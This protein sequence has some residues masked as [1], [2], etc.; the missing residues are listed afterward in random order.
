MEISAKLSYLRIA[1]R[2]TR[3]LADLVRGKS[4]K[5][6][7]TVLGFTIKKGSLPV[8]K[9]LNQ[10]VASAINN[11][12]LEAD[13]L[14]IAKITVDEG[15]KYKRWRPRARGQ[16]YEIQKK[17]SHITIILEEKVKTKKKK[18]GKVA[19]IE[20]AD[21]IQE[22]TAKTESGTSQA[23]NREIQ[24]GTGSLPAAGRKN[25]QKNIQT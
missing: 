7:Q 15:P 8:L 9:L 13:N 17:T 12:Q 14:Y 22:K 11:F 4:V 5:E 3:L 1:P 25:R 10:A 16:A 6:A 20:K 19:E 23:E 18:A 2:K 21:I 24:A